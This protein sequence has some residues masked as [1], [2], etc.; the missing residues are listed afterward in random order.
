[1]NQNAAFAQNQLSVRH[2]A[3]ENLA[4]RF[5]TDF[6]VISVNYLVI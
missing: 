6:I 1:M 4:S 5:P 2:L 3:R